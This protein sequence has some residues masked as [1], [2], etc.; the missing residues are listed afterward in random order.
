[1]QTFLEETIAKL[2]Q[3]HSSLGDLVLI[4]P[5]KRAGGFLKQYLKRA[6]HQTTFAPT[7]IS[8][9]EFIETLSGLS[10]L[11]NLELLF[12]AYEAYLQTDSKEE[13]E[14]F[15]SFSNWGTTLLND[16]NEID[17]HLVPQEKFFSYL[18]NI[19][20][21]ERWTMDEEPTPLIENYLAFFDNLHKTYSVLKKNLTDNGFGYQGLVYR[22]AAE[23]VDTYSIR[24]KET[25]HVF[26]GF[27]ALNKAEQHIFQTLLNYGNAEVY[28]DTDE[29]FMQDFSH[30]ASYFL[31]NYRKNWKYY[32]QHSFEGIENHY[33][34]PKDISLVE[35]PKNIGQAKYIGS[36]L[37]GI[38]TKELS[39]TAIVLGDEALLLPLLHSL[40][41]NIPSVN[42]TMG[43]PIG[44]FPAYVFF[45]MVLHL[46]ALPEDSFYY[47]DI[48]S[49]LQ[50]PM[51]N[52]LLNSAETIQ[53]TIVHNNKTHLTL[54]ELYSMANQE[55]H[56]F[57]T[58][59]FQ[60]ESSPKQALANYQSLVFALKDRIGGDRI[61]RIVLYELYKIFEKLIS[62]N[63]NYQ[64]IE[65]IKQLQQLFIEMAQTTSLDLQGDAYD[66]LQIM[67]VLE[68]R[69]LDFENI[70]IT[71]VN[72]GILPTG[73][74]NASFITYDLKQTFE[75]PLYTEKDAIYAYHFYHM[76][77]RA[78]KVTC[79]Y[80]N[81]SEGVSIG[82]KSRF[83][84]QLEINHPPAHNLQHT[85]VAPTVEIPDTELKIIQKTPKVIE[86]L[87]EIAAKGFSPSALTA[88]IRNPIDFY[89]E[90]VLRVSENVEVEETVAA[91]TL[92]TIIH[93]TLEQLYK[94]F[95]KTELTE[96]LL[97]GLFNKIEKEVIHQFQNTFKEGTFN[98]GKNLIIFEVAKRYIENF[99]HSEIDLLRKGHSIRLISVE[100]NLDIA[101]DIPSL[102]FPVRLKGKVDRID[103]FD[104][105]KRIIDYKTGSVSQ[106]EVEIHDWELLKEDY[107]YSKAFQ[108]LAYAYVL[109][110]IAP[111]PE[112][113]AGVISF[114]NLGS[115]FL[116][117]ATKSSLRS[118]TKNTTIDTDVFSDFE[119][120]LF[121]LIEEIMNPNLP[122]TEK[123]IV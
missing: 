78:K 3:K 81:Y 46:H 7:I 55:D 66:G 96:S 84:L 19:K 11:P 95:E 113:E 70:I 29:Y 80:S 93:D 13:K 112:V 33:T 94:Q 83:L 53:H 118:R 15:E 45:E 50:H 60:K 104:G 9:E 76:L 82:E 86:R 79:L 23:A 74:S 101:L 103:E 30:S 40:P 35:V 34:K 61:T 90:R 71:S 56:K 64:H 20:A 41:E 122:F 37:E 114:K 106:G 43:V 10:I 77:H 62:L 2:Q 92:G 89:Y 65:N 49:I 27:N 116:P 105:K 111:S 102:D 24:N 59:L 54:Q 58:L 1:M 75:L 32:E 72:E 25:P 108:V 28:W 57:L 91:N 68:T 42:V 17:R 115:G 121:Q 47:K 5:S 38:P 44:G 48:L 18:R 51:G 87:K 12:H 8:I 67:G 52:K 39:K 6:Q 119:Q 99:I 31:R 88:Y 120:I 26:I 110:D 85:V 21:L 22:K 98:K 107:K 97:K 63:S 16:F 100:S 69:V 109:H 4:L 73:K 117:F 123:E 36:L 14:A